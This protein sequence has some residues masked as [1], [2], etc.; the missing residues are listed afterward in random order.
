MGND[1]PHIAGIIQA[2]LI[3]NLTHNYVRIKK[4][5][6]VVGHIFMLSCKSRWQWNQQLLAMSLTS[7]S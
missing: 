2:A 3:F 4:S 1:L 6:C 7:Q 5:V